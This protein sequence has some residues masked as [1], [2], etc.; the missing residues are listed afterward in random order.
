MPFPENYRGLLQGLSAAI[1]ASGGNPRVYI[2]NYGGLVEA[3]KDLTDAIVSGGGGGGGLTF[4]ADF[5]G[6]GTIG[7]P[8]ALSTTGVSAGT[9]GSDV[10]I[11]VI[12][13]DSKG[14][15]TSL[16][17]VSA[18]AAGGGLTSVSRTSDLSGNGTGGNPLGL[19][20]QTVTPATYGDAVSTV[21]VTVNDKGIVTGIAS[22]T[23]RTASTGQTGIVQLNAATNSTSDSQA[24]TPSAVKA[25][26]DLAT[27]AANTANAAVPA[28]RQVIAGT[29]LSGGGSLSS[30]V[31][32]NAIAASVSQAG[33]VQ[34]NNTT[35]S[36]STTQAAT[37]NA[38]KIAYDIAVSADA[39]ANAAAPATRQVIAGTGLSGG[40]AL[41]SN[42]TLNAIA[43]STVQA[44]IVQLNTATNST[45]DS[46][47]AT[48]S[49][50][51]QAY[52]LAVAAV[53]QVRTLQ[54]TTNNGLTGGGAAQDL[55][56][57]RSF[58]FGLTGQA[59]ALH[60]LAANGFTVRTGAGTFTGRAL[61]GGTGISVT[62]G[63]GVAG[64]PAIAASIASQAQAEAGTNTTTLMTPQ[65]TAQAIAALAGAGSVVVETFTSSGNFSEDPDDVVYFVEAWGG[66]GSGGVAIRSATNASAGGGGGG[67]YASAWLLP[68]Q[69]S[70]PVT[71]TVG[72]GGAA[73]TT[74][75]AAGSAIGNS[76]GN[77]SFG[78]FLTAYGGG[79]GGFNVN[80]LSVSGGGGG[81]LTSAGGVGFLHIPGLPTPW[82]E[83]ATA[84]IRA[85]VGLGVYGGGVGAYFSWSTNGKSSVFGGGGGGGFATSALT[86][87]GSIYGGGGGGS[88]ADNGIA[89]SGG[90]SVFG[91]AGGAGTSNGNGV[92][93]SI[94][95]GGG[96]GGTRSASGSTTSGAGGRGEVRVWRFKV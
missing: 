18:A 50:V 51:K 65:R 29:G 38:V 91:G 77:S 90:T 53:P 76:G 55:S 83:T 35:N 32:L 2:P 96:G 68:S 46:Q 81:G 93:G 11:P 1:V 62:N 15:I 39:T 36:T 3:I 58:T 48:P 86:A 56:A 4:G 70:S 73:K 79:P 12:Q 45:S 69:I 8:I 14:R 49:A 66:G 52:D 82:V 94:P 75:N 5:S 60:N 28:T 30:N 33:I 37:A 64:D 74:T 95:G 20:T 72:A 22:Q 89:L 71:V 57:N 87:G 47:A 88:G 7:D 24:A 19:A 6:V 34:L 61:Q 9:Y 44:G 41:S 31:T 26:F 16:S 23:I 54:F 42:V 67:A 92:D 43:G 25:A 84:D 17:T 21:S 63:D 40:G 80:S 78:S 59:L 13:T 85:I 27:T 10:Q